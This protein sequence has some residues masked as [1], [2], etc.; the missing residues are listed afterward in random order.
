MNNDKGKFVISL[1]FELHWG[2]AERWSANQKA[3][4]FDTT[5][6]IIPLV[7]ELFE[8]YD[9]HAT[10]ASV[11]FLF[12]KDK[13]QLL[14]FLPLEKPTYR[15]MQLSYYR[16]IENSEVGFD[17]ND[18]PY[19]YA[20]SLIELILKTPNQELASHTFSHYYCMENGQNE[21]QF[22][23]DLSAA[24]AIAKENFNVELKSLVFPRN[25]FNAE[26]ISVAKQ[27]GIKVVRTNPS[28]WF[29]KT[30]LKFNSI[31]RAFDSVVPI[32][33]TLSFEEEKCSK[34]EVLQLPASRFL[35]PFSEKEKVIQNLKLERVK[36]EMTCAAKNR[37]VFHL[38]WHPHNFGNS[39]LENLFYLEKILK[40][41]KKLNEEFDYCS[42]SMIEMY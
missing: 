34:D 33:S 41:Y 38:W 25:Q 36:S 1:D 12:A 23:A 5:R 31:A 28:V 29:W 17:E 40:H 14:R 15:N 39:P 18:D 32:S 20:S 16:L 35:R 8:K 22:N 30:D 6:R 19:H 4:Y 11:G 2:S 27:N 10:W 42:S 13:N 9:I 24:Q 3:H 26:Y 7:L 37:R 21:Y